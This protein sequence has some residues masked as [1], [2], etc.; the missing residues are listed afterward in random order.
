MTHC[1]HDSSQRFNVVMTSP[2]LTLTDAQGGKKSYLYLT[3]QPPSYHIEDRQEVFDLA[4]CPVQ[5]PHSLFAWFVRN[6]AWRVRG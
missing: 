2:S 4:F 1:A 6:P 3:S 5:L